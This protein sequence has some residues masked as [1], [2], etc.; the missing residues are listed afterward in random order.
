VPFTVVDAVILLLIVGCILYGW[1]TGL[2]RQ[3]V[4]V[5][6]TIFALMLANVGYEF[7]G[8]WWAAAASVVSP[9][10]LDALAYLLILLVAAVFWLTVMRRIYPYTRIASSEVGNWAWS[11][12]RFGGLIVGGLLGVLVALAVVGTAELMAYYRWGGQPGASGVRNVV[13]DQVT[14]SAILRETF[15][16]APP[17]A[18]L[19]GYWVPGI[20]RARE[21]TILP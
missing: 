15:V 18:D 5:S 20:R 3:V 8:G 19:L 2:V 13:H 12:D 16:E 11:L 14:G 1:R 9:T 6:A 21:G 17:A 4:A 10:Y 7:L